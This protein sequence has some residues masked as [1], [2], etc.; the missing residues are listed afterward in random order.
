MELSNRK[1]SS[2]MW[3]RFVESMF[4]LKGH[5]RVAA[6]LVLVAVVGVGILILSWVF[7]S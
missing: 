6:V 7:R 2:A 5:P 4:D 3:L 1:E